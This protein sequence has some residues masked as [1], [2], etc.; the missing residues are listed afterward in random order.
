MLMGCASPKESPKPA[1]RERE[2]MRALGLR[3]KT[4]W[5]LY[6]ALRQEASG[7]KRLTPNEVPDWTGLWVWNSNRGFLFD[8]DTPQG[9]VTT[10]RL[11]PE[12]QRKLDEEIARINEGIEYDPISSCAPPGHPRWLAIPFLREFIVTPDQTWLSSETVNNVRRIYTDGRDHIPEVDR[13]PLYYGDSIGFWNNQALTIHTNQLRA[14]IY[15]RGNPEYTDQVETVEIWEKVEDRTVEV[16]VWVYDPPALVD[17]WYVKQR[18]SKITDDDKQLRIRYWD[19]LENP[20]NT[21]YKTQEGSTQF[22]DFTFTKS[23]DR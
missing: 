6:Q 13:Y 12:Y 14:G 7:G 18:Y 10:A 21:V 20:N 11:T 4:A 17:P 8:P 9:V 5:D 16:D 3:H 19:C 2:A 23:D 1:Q 22:K 15:Q